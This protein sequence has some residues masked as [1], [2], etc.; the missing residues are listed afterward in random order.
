MATNSTNNSSTFWQKATSN[1]IVVFSFCL[2]LLC[3][4]IGVLLVENILINAL[5][6]VLCACSSGYSVNVYTEMF[7]NQAEIQN[8]AEKTFDQVYSIV[9]QLLTK[10]KNIGLTTEELSI[11]DQLTIIMLSLKK[12]YK[13]FDEHI[14][15]RE[16]KDMEKEPQ[17]WQ[18][19]NLTQVPV[20]SQKGPIEVYKGVLTTL[21]H[22]Y[23]STTSGSQ[24]IPPTNQD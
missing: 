12:Y 10:S 20:F 11:L 9:K 2:A 14:I 7:K 6:M 13:D 17:R 1:T 21:S 18:V 3:A 24:F 5:M 4:V 23:R 8:L 15:W 19:P 22:E 16:L